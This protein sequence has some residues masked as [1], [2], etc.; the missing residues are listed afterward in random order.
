MSASSVTEILRVAVEELQGCSDSARLDAQL[1]LGKVLNTTRTILI[2]RG[3][4][5]VSMAARREFDNLLARRRSGTPIAYLLGTQ[6]FWSLSLGVTPAVLVPRPE[7]EKL[8]E[9]ALERIPSDREFSILDLGTGSGAI[10]LAI[11]SERPRARVTAV[12]VSPAALEVAMAN[13]QRL[14]LTTIHWRL[15]SW[16]DGVPGERF[17]LIVANPPYVGRHDPALDKLAAEPLIALTPGF[18][19]MEAIEAIVIAAPAHLNTSG[20]LIFEHGHTQSGLVNDLLGR[21]GFTEICSHLDFAGLPRVTLGTV[22]HNIRNA[23]DS[24]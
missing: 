13:A 12:D 21:G 10:A 5:N 7:T 15:G 1:L 19:G 16:F 3:D 6:E 11:A 20:R 14:G 4:Q 8:V 2:A 9:L 23:H 17:D 24:L 18:T 22:Q